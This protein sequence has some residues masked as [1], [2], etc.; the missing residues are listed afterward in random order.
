MRNRV[1]GCNH[2]RLRFTA[3]PFDQPAGFQP[4]GSAVVREAEASFVRRRFPGFPA[5]FCPF[6]DQ[7]SWVRREGHVGDRGC[8]GPSRRS[9]GH[10][11]GR[12]LE[13][14]RSS[15]GHRHLARVQ[16]GFRGAGR[17]HRRRGQ[18]SS[19]KSQVPGTDARRCFAQGVEVVD[20]RRSGAVGG[21]R[22]ARRA[23]TGRAVREGG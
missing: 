10:P 3:M 5:S 6:A 12:T 2:H 14:L 15:P 8:R 11:L 20:R 18:R 4:I 17:G 13:S 23:A 1:R 7:A 19:G 16:Y 22:S 21:G 9:I